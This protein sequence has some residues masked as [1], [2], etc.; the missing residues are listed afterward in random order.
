MKEMKFPRAAINNYQFTIMVFILLV[1]YGIFSYVNMP[2]TEDPEITVPGASVIAVYPGA[3]PVDLEELVAVPLEDAINELDDIK[4]I[5]TTLRDGICIIG[6]EFI[7]GTNAKDKY[8]EVVQKVNSTREVMPENL[9]SLET[10]QWT[11][12]DVNILQLALISESAAYSELY[13]EAEKIEKEI[14][15]I[16][17][18]KNVDIIACPEEEVKIS[19]DFEKM[20]QMNIS[21]D[22]VSN[23]IISN[24]AN[25]PGG[26]I[27]ISG[28]VFGVKTSGSYDN[29]QEI[30]NTIVSSYQDR[31]I[32]FKDI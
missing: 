17:S 21:L 4:K 13:D 15:K 25:I 22:K 16:R 9:Y 30:E 8:D 5:N 27:D 29:L 6:V 31:I 1:I 19:L 14:K 26:T 24:N 7:F 3:N 20:A 18:V 28:K 23:A 11:T 2:R 10:M 32:Y 12:S